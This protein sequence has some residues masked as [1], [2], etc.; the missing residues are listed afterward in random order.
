MINFPVQSGMGT[1][2]GQY[3]DFDRDIAARNVQ[4]LGNVEATTKQYCRARID[5]SIAMLTIRFNFDLPANEYAIVPKS[6]E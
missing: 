3:G 4:W 1:V 6:H 2:G 5:T